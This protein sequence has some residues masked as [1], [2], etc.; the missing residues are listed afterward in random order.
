MDRGEGERE[1][2]ER[3]KEES[4]GIEGGRSGAEEREGG[5][6]RK[7]NYHSAES[8]TKTIL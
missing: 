4:N 6:R 1:G 5:N 7:A 3:G 2:E 8:H